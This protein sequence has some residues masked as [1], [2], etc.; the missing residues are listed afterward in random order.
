MSRKPDLT[1]LSNILEKLIL[2]QKSLD[3]AVS[4][5]IKHPR[6]VAGIIQNFE[7]VFELTW[8][9]LKRLLEVLGHDAPSAREVFKMAYKV[10]LL[11]D[12]DLWLEILDAR[13]LTSHTYNKKV[14]NILVKRIKAKYAA[15]FR[16][17]TDQISKRVTKEK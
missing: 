15:A 9:T 12:E 17:L 16:K 4:L 5:P 7:F 6:D 13:N 10:D 8:K 1:K 14:A 11:S 3:E 2:A